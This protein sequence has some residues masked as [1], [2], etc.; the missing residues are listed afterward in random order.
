[1]GTMQT[2]RRIVGL[3]VKSRSLEYRTSQLQARHF[4][5]VGFEVALIRKNMSTKNQNDSNCKFDLFPLNTAIQGPSNGWIACCK[6]RNLKLERR[7]AF[8]KQVIYDYIERG[9]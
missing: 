8:L 7:Q 5:S 9:H 6:F 3:L 2:F 4:H 1:M